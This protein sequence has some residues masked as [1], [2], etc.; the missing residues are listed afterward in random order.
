[1]FTEFSVQ[2]G[3]QQSYKVLGSVMLLMLLFWAG[4]D[5]V[6]LDIPLV[7]TALLGL[8]VLLISGKGA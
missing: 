7:G 4:S 3:T 8:S 5:A 1:M 6:F 2:R